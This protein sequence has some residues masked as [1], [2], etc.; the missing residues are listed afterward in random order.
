M[1]VPAPVAPPAHHVTIELDATMV[2]PPWIQGALL[3]EP[4]DTMQR[5]GG[6]FIGGARYEQLLTA[7]GVIVVD[8]VRFDVSGAGLRTHQRGVRTVGKMIGHTW[9]SGYW[10]ATRRGFGLQQHPRPGGGFYFSEG[11]VLHEGRLIGARV[12]EAPVLRH[13]PA[14][15][16]YDVR[17]SSELGDTVIHGRTVR[18]T[19]IPLAPPNADNPGTVMSQACSMF[20][21]DGDLGHGMCERSG[22][23]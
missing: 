20:D 11:Y 10:P 4:S 12:V 13:V 17:L 15:E 3:P 21:C 9:I 1:V 8:G 6:Q 19:F 5:E 23:A 7:T 14:G 16:D 18:A 2:A 22:P